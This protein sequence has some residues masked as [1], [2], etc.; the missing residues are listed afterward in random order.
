MRIKIKKPAVP[1][2]A[3]CDIAFLLFI[4]IMVLTV[5]KTSMPEK[6]EKAKGTEAVESIS[7]IELYIADD[8]SVSAG[9]QLDDNAIL[10]LVK[11][12]STVSL[13]A[14]R[15]C[16]FKHIE[17]VQRLLKEAGCKNCI[18]TVDKK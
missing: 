11:P 5:F 15:K 6:F 4:F 16:P 13:C 2:N 7:D 8:G 3:M 17:R 14:S 18:F 1:M 10:Q 12:D 9:V